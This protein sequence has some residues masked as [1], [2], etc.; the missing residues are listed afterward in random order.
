LRTDSLRIEPLIDTLIDMDWVARVE[1]E[2]AQRLVLLVD[3]ATTPAAPLID[4]ALISST[5]ATQH[6]R[7]RMALDTMML[8]DLVG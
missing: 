5:P 3:P 1:E 6:L 8:A 2:G 7:Q 4:R